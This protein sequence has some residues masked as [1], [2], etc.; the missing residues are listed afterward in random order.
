T[1]SRSP[2]ATDRLALARL[3][4]HAFAQPLNA[5]HGD[6]LATAQPVRDSPA[7]L[8]PRARLDAA[9][10]H[11]PVLVEHEDEA[12]LPVLENGR[13]GHHGQFWHVVF[14]YGQRDELVGQE[15]P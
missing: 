3:H 15:D 8:H 12:T 13:L 10:G 5:L 14:A 9:L 7:I 2:R 11:R 4:G 1:G 6:E